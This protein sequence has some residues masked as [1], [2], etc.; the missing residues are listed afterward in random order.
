LII[1]VETTSSLD[2][3][4]TLEPTIATMSAET[5]N[6]SSESLAT[7]QFG[8]DKG[9][10]DEESAYQATHHST[11]WR[12]HHRG[13]LALTGINALLACTSIYAI[14]TSVHCRSQTRGW[15]TELL[16]ARGAI[17]Y[18]ER[19]YTGA[20][21]FDHSKGGAVRLNDAEMEFFGPPSPAI[22]ASWHYLLH[23]TYSRY[24]YVVLANRSQRR[25]PCHDRERGRAL[26]A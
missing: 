23:G 26:L 5:A 10:L 21:T 8:E 18:E 4:S 15:D 7:Q 20:L 11:A 16:D 25:V 17:Q 24:M 6:K 1:S 12:W 13:W 19:A 14:T 22:E 9:L 2:A 3:K